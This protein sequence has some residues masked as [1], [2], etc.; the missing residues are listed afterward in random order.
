MIFTIILDFFRFSGN[1]LFAFHGLDYYLQ[2]S[3]CYDVASVRKRDGA[4]RH[5]TFYSNAGHVRVSRKRNAA[6]G[7]MCCPF[8]S[9][10]SAADSLFNFCSAPAFIF[11]RLGGG[12]AEAQLFLLFDTIHPTLIEETP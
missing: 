11:M 4:L 6:V 5:D 12:C 8:F 9:G 7:G 1:I 10:F 3:P 2:R